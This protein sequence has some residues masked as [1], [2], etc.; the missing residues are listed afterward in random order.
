[1]FCLFCTTAGKEHRNPLKVVN[2]Y[3]IQHVPCLQGTREKTL[4][5]IRGWVDDNRPTAESIFFLLDVPGSGKST[6][7]KHM[8]EEWKKEK[9][10]LAKFFFSRD[11]PET[12]STSTFCLTVA[13]AFALL[14][15]DFNAY[16]SKF[17][18]RSDFGLLSFEELFEGL[19]ANPLRSIRRRA[20]LIIDALD[21]CDNEYHHRDNLLSTLNSRL[22]SVP[23]LRILVTSRPERD[24]KQWAKEKF[25]VGYSDFNRLEEGSSDVE[26]YIKHRLRDQTDIQHRIYLVIRHAEGLFIWARVAC[27][28][29]VNAD[30]INALLEE[31][32][33]EVKLDHLYKTALGQSKPKDEPSQRAMV[34]V[35]QMIL[36]AR[37]PLSIAEMEKLCPRPEIVQSVVARLSSLLLYED[38]EDPIRLLHTTFREFLTV[39]ARAGDYFIQFKT[40]HCTLASGCLSLLSHQFKNGNPDPDLLDPTSKRKDIPIDNVFIN[41]V[42]S[43]FDYASTSWAYHCTNSHRESTLDEQI[44]EF[45]TNGFETWFRFI[46]QSATY[47]ATSSMRDV[48]SLCHQKLVRLSSYA[49]H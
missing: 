3:G 35:L 28:L 6:V 5:A 9:R 26:V 12:M 47:S 7:A 38:R 25:G 15:H 10:L 4:K 22:S 19:V 44:R 18:G 30:D 42:L 34:T 2:A 39:Q 21:E 11:T 48:L 49:T 43:A 16:M 29:I 14:D 17:K 46:G 27:D 45:T 13:N 20:I 23:R 8:A 37:Q 32:G 31:L 1:M 41:R 24:I 40:G 36:A 33:K